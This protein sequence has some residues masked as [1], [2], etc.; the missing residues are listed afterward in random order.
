MSDNHQYAV[1]DG[2]HWRIESF[3]ALCADYD[4]APAGVVDWPSRY[5]GHGLGLGHGL[6][7]L[8]HFLDSR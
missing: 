3:T 8:W 7:R 1:P 4:F 5:G 6:L 2:K